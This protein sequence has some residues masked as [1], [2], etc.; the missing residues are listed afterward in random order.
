MHVGVQI[1]LQ[2]QELDDPLITPHRPVVRREDCFGGVAEHVDY[3]LDVV[4]PRVRVTHLG[5]AEGE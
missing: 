5:A 1:S 3:L 4:R 2:R